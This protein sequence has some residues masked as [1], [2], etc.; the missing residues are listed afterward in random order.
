MSGA[1]NNDLVKQIET[2]AEGIK[3][4]LKKTNTAEKKWTP[5]ADGTRLAQVRSASYSRFCR[6]DLKEDKKN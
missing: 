5:T 6:A 3:S 4:H 2:D 1:P